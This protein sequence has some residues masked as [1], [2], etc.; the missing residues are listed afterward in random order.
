MVVPMHFVLSWLPFLPTQAGGLHASLSLLSHL[1]FRLE[2]QSL[3]WC[4]IA[5]L[6]AWKYVAHPLSL[7][8]FMLFLHN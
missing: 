1:K 8:Y 5:S 2:V 4:L 7:P 3:R 6:C